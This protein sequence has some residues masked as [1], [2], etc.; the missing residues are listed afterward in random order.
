AQIRVGHHSETQICAAEVGVP[1]VRVVQ[2]RIE[3]IRAE[4]IATGEVA[5]GQVFSD[6]V[7]VR[8]L[9]DGFK[10]IESQLLSRIAIHEGK[11]LVRAADAAGEPFADR[12]P[13]L[14][15][16]ASVNLIAGKDLQTGRRN[17]R[18][19]PPGDLDAGTVRRIQSKGGRTLR[20][21]HDHKA[22]QK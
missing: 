19:G 13:T 11:R 15:I 3:Q 16:R 8:Q 17:D 5:L 12:R 21:R 4:Q 6:Q 18:T 7:G 1:E 2:I 9:N 20:G 14:Q 22:K 10:T